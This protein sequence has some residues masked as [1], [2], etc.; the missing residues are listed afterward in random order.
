MTNPPLGAPPHVP[1]VETRAEVSAL[2]AFGIPQINIA[3]R[4][5]ISDETLRK[6]YSYELENGLQDANAKV[7]GVLFKK[8]VDQEE[9]AAVVFWLKTRARWSEKN[10]NDDSKQAL[11]IIEQILSMKK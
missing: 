4:L 7:A 10:A 5:R 6:Y 9:T 11:S 8:A 2:V 1:T 3:Q